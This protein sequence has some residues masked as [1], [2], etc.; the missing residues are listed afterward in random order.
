MGRSSVLG[1]VQNKPP[2]CLWHWSRARIR[3]QKSVGL[4]KSVDVAIRCVCFQFPPFAR[5]RHIRSVTSRI[6]LNPTTAHAGKTDHSPHAHRLQ[7]RTRTATAVHRRR[8]K[9]RHH[10]YTQKCNAAYPSYALSKP[11]RRHVGHTKPIPSN[12]L[13]KTLDR[14]PK[15]GNHS[16]LARPANA[17]KNI[18]LHGY[19]SSFREEVRRETRMPN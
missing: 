16:Q 9:V 6:P 13:P 17:C 12:G 10:F 19:C 4:C 8:K 3:T 11:L 15:A 5:M 18:N 1:S 7:S 2:I 14:W